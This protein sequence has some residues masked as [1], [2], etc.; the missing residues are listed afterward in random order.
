MINRFYAGAY[1]GV[2]YKYTHIMQG[3]KFNLFTNKK[4]TLY[5]KML[6]QMIMGEKKSYA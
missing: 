1:I 3:V 2:H 6:I 5:S 4:E